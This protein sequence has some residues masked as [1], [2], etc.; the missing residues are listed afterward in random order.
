LGL[1]AQLLQPDR[2]PLEVA[3]KVVNGN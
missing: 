1:P 3:P 2:Q